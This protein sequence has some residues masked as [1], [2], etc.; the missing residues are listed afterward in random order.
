MPRFTIPLLLTVEADTYED[1]FEHA[2]GVAAGVGD[3]ER[4]SLSAEHV[5][6]HRKVMAGSPHWV[7]GHALYFTDKGF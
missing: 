2:D 6:Q 5:N 4:V 1:A 3:L 7:T